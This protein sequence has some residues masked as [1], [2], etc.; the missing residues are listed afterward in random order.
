MYKRQAQEIKSKN[1]LDK[2][3]LLK[4]PKAHVFRDGKETTIAVEE[5]VLDDC[6][7]LR[8]G[9]QIPADARVASGSIQVNEALIT[10]EADE[11]TKGKDA[12]LLSGSFVVSGECAAVLTAVGRD[13]Y[14]SCLLYTSNKLTA[15]NTC[16]LQTSMI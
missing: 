15:K 4:M 13:S 7:I 2:L 14:I 5:L 12:Q 1:T 9:G 3:K 8:A 10:G 11:I 16:F 6:V